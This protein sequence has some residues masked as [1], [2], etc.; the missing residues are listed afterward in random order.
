M[1]PTTAAHEPT[2]IDGLL[3][4][5]DQDVLEPRPW[6]RMQSAWATELS[7]MLGP[8]PLVELCCGVGHI[9]LLTA[10]DSRRHAWLVDADEHACALARRNATRAGLDDRV[11]VV[12]HRVDGR[13]VP[14]VPTG[15]PLVLADPPYL[16][17]DAADRTGDPEHAV[18]GGADGLDLVGSVLR[19]AVEHLA[20]DGICLLQTR[21]AGQAAEIATRL[22]GEWAHLGLAS[23]AVRAADEQ[24]AVQLLSPRSGAHIGPGTGG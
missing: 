17:S 20:P 9:G 2:S 8:G 13:R 22:R 18:D 21:G 4:E 24:R 10:R 7:A 5:W 16:P 11:Q 1:D 23:S 14:G 12:A 3:V 6:T 19:T 15:A